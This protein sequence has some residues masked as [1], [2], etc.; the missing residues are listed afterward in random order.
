MTWSLT[1][2]GLPHAG[3]NSKPHNYKQR[4]Q[5]KKDLPI[6]CVL[7]GKQFE[8]SDEKRTETVFSTFQK[9]PVEFKD[10]ERVN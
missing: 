1:T 4:V 2:A 5:K 7:T 10:S 3:A 6:K 8:G 9:N